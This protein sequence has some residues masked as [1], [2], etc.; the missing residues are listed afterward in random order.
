MFGDLWR[1]TWVYANVVHGQTFPTF[2]KNFA[3]EHNLY[4]DNPRL[5]RQFNAFRVGKYFFDSHR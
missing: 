5:Q 1:S 2:L 3:K 4:G